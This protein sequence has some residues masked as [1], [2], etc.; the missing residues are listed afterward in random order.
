MRYVVAMIFALV[1][2]FL[3]MWFLSGAVASW[4]VAHMSF[5]SPDQNDNWFDAVFMAMNILGLIVGWGIGWAVAG[6]L[7]RDSRPT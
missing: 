7:G 1:G 3:T 6:S 5:E 4:A 2:A